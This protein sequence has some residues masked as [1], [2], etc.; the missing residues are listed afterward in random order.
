MLEGVLGDKVVMMIDGT[1]SVLVSGQVRDGV[2]ILRIQ[3]NSVTVE[4]DGKQRQIRM[5]DS[6]VVA[7]P[8]KQRESV[9]VTVA[10][11]SRGMYM[12]TG[13]INELPVS[14]IVD[15]GATTIAMNALQAKRLGID[16]RFKGKLTTVATASGAAKAYYVTL[17]KVS[18]GSIS[19]N[20]IPAVVIDGQYPVQVLLGMSFLGKLEIQHEG[21]V[22][23]LK[24]KY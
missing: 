9:T 15:T 23:R 12:A 8:Y 14:F 3:P 17:D 4:I 6:S 24:K 11:D 21:T 20:N 19:L 13:S 2:K 16:Y 5:G 7:S 18:I 1:R 10:P 22:M